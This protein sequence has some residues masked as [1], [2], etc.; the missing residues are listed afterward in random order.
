[1][2]ATGCSPGW[3]W[4]PFQL[5]REVAR[6]VLTH[7][8]LEQGKSYWALSPWMGHAGRICCVFCW[9]LCW[10]WGLPEDLPS[11]HQAEGRLLCV[12]PGDGSEGLR[13]LPPRV[14]GCFL[15]PVRGLGYSGSFRASRDTPG[16]SSWRFPGSPLFP[17]SQPAEV[18]LGPGGR[19]V[20]TCS[21]RIPRSARGPG[22][23]GG[24]QVECNRGTAPCLVG[25][26]GATP[27]RHTWRSACSRCRLR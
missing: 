26:W 2:P 17:C 11:W 20:T 15:S 10:V 6:L 14:P 25:P 24:A 27:P 3:A 16:F 4:P 8:K 12:P 5:A 22:L 23:P 21:A 13:G 19:R 1:M 7:Y 9:V 18:L